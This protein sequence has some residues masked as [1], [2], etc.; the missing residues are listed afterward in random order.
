MLCHRGAGYPGPCHITADRALTLREGFL[1]ISLQLDGLPGENFLDVI[2]V[3]IVVLA[4]GF[5]FGNWYATNAN[6]GRIVAMMKDKAR[7]TVGTQSQCTDKRW[8]ATPRF[9]VLPHMSDGVF[10]LSYPS[11]FEMDYVD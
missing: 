3:I 5:V 1:R 11:H 8:Y 4:I 7:R 9:Q 10:D 6:R 2:G